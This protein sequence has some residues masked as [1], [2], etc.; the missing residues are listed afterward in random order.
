MDY[1]F[2]GRIDRFGVGRERKVWYTVL[3]LPDGLATALP[4]GRFPRLR[5]EGEIADVPVAG[6]WMPTG[7]GRRYFIVSPRVLK[8]AGVGLG[9]LVEM[10]FGIAD[11]DAVDVPA[12]LADAL[13]RDEGA[14]AAWDALTPGRRRGLAHRVHG[15]RTPETRA[16]RVAEVIAELN[17]RRASVRRSL[18]RA[19]T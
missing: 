16:R 4:F 1:D 5:V 11:Q 7:D 8:D 19:R 3:F 9:D 10:R 14:R 15:A 12:A 2:E 18:S 13:V 6:A 17:G